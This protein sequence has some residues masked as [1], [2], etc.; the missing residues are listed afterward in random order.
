MAQDR[1]VVAQRMQ[2]GGRR[3]RSGAFADRRRR[4]KPGFS[5]G[6]E[7][8][9]PLAGLIGRQDAA[10]LVANSVK[11]FLDAWLDLTTDALQLPLMLSEDAF[12][13]CDLFSGKVKI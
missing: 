12:D 13:L 2:R 9:L 10:D 5:F 6:G 4:W 3:I 1:R 7:P 8:F 11:L